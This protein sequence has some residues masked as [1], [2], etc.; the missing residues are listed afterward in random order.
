MNLNDMNFHEE[1]CIWPSSVYKAAVVFLSI[2]SGS[3]GHPR[4]P[5]SPR[6]PHRTPRPTH[7]PRRPG[8]PRYGPDVCEGHFDTMAILR[9][10]MFV[11]KVSL[12][13]L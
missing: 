13:L 2:G 11:F 1:D 3:G 6:T 7:P 12:S 5:V 4:P 8:G 9:G 10:E